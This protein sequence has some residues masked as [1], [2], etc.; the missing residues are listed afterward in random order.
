[1][2]WEAL[3][4]IRGKEKSLGQNER[5]HVFER[6]EVKGWMKIMKKMMEIEG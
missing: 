5:V 4:P 6:V 2:L 3:A 1:M